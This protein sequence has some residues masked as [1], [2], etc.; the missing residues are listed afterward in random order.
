VRSE[1][2]DREDL[3]VID[4]TCP[5]VAKVHVEARRFA[6]QEYDLVLIGHA[7]HE[8]VIGTRGEAPD[9]IRVVSSLDDVDQLDL[10]PERPLA[11]LTQTTLAVDETAEIIDALKARVP[12][13]VGPNSNDI[14]YATQNRQDAV[15]SIAHRCDLMLV[16]GSRNSSNTARLVE[17]AE[18]EGCRAELIEDASQL[19][20]SWLMGAR[21]IGVTSGASVPEVLVEEVVRSLSSLGPAHLSEERIVQE[22]MH[23]ALPTKVR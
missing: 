18:R 14:C 11:Y 6:A 23:F 22:T 5:L 8:E 1:A 10:D 12:A 19:E 13:L 20:L 15:R 4:A 2:A 16:V 7:D 9:R 21:S 3:N 17:V